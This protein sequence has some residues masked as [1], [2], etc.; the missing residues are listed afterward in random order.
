[1][2]VVD[3][4]WRINSSAEIIIIIIIIINKANKRK[5]RRR[6]AY[7]PQKRT[8][9]FFCV[10]QSMYVLTKCQDHFQTFI[11]STV[12]S[13][14]LFTCWAYGLEATEYLRRPRYALLHLATSL[15]LLSSHTIVYLTFLLLLFF[16]CFCCLLPHCHIRIS[17][18]SY[19]HI[20][21]R[22]LFY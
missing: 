16:P 22:K 1:M 8:E 10:Y 3:S 2:N 15:S 11:T 9:P 13:I 18:V 20:F 7:L 12:L 6:T 21:S 19:L 17:L 5:G 14:Y 4:C